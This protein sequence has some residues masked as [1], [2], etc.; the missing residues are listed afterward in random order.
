MPFP[1]RPFS[2]SIPECVKHGLPQTRRR[3]LSVFD[4]HAMDEHDLDC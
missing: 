2:P 3:G 1:E 4:Q